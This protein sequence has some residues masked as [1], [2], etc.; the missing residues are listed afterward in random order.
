MRRLLCVAAVVLIW[1]PSAPGHAVSCSPTVFIEALAYPVGASARGIAVADFDGD[2]TPDVATANLNP[3][4]VSVLLNDGTG[5][6]GSPIATP[7]P[8]DPMAIAAADLRGTG[9]MDVVVA[10]YNGVYVLLGHGDGTFDPPTFSPSETDNIASMVIGKFDSNASPDIV[11]GPSYSSD[12]ISV[13]PGIGDGTF[14]TALVTLSAAPSFWMTAADIHDDGHL[15]LVTSGGNSGVVIVYPGLGDGTFGPNS[16]FIA[17][18]SLYGVTTG[19]LDEDG[20]LDLAV[21]SG[22]S[23]SI[24]LG[25]GSGGF[26][27]ALQYAANVTAGD[28]AVGD[29]DQDG[30]LDIVAAEPQDYSSDGDEVSYLRGR[31]DGSFEPGLTYAAGGTLDLALADLNGDSLLDVVSAGG[32]V[33]VS[34]A[35]PDGSLLAVPNS[36]LNG[37]SNPNFTRGDWNGDRYVDFAWL[38]GNQ[39]LV[40]EATGDGRFREIGTLDAGPN[41]QS[42][43]VASGHF[44]DPG[45]ADLVVSTYSDILLFQGNGDG[46]FQAPVSIFNGSGLTAIEVGDLDGDGAD[47]IVAGPNCCGF[48]IVAL[49]GNGEG[50]FDPAV[51]TSIAG[52][53]YDLVSASLTDASPPGASPRDDLIVVT[54][55]N[56]QVLLSNGDGTFAVTTTIPGFNSSVAVGDFNGGGADLLISSGNPSLSLYPGNGD[57][58]FQSPIVIALST[59]GGSVAAGYYNADSFLDFAVRTEGNIFVFFGLGDLHFLAPIRLTTDISATFVETVDFTGNGT[60]DLAAIGQQGIAAFRNSRLGALVRGG[61]SVLIG[62]AVVLEAGAS[63]Y[64]SLTYQWRKDGVPLS[65]GGRISGSQTATLAIDP[66]SFSDA[67][68]Y[69]VVVTDLCATATSNPAILSVEFADVPDSSPFHDDIIAVATAGITGGCGGADF[70]PTSPVRRDQMAVF[71]L[72]AEHGA[73]YTPPACSGVFSDVACPGPFT[74]WVE[75]L[76]TEGV[77]A[78]CG[79]GNYCPDASVTRAQMAVFLLKTSQ[80]SGYGPPPATGIFGDVPAGSFAADFIED[81]YNRGITGGCSSSP[82]LYCPNNAVLRQQMAT[83]LV[84]TFLGP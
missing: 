58:T 49:M 71:L 61:G 65:D 28:L 72:K 44:I 17:G 74:D 52:D 15:D 7:I 80:G 38:S 60:P 26:E 8:N 37:T 9:T 21:G 31:G 3:R 34:L 81:L 46:T 18:A 55:G 27:A 11:L 10:T 6:L 39:V 1:A 29:L 20:N 22:N 64:G 2:L 32:D 25:D 5:G 62:S 69:D 63:G 68:S 73:A 33:F 77:T 41:V 48:S 53:V 19:D 66:V 75:Q 43:G 12:E 23:I 70:C 16:G 56:V 36:R 67:G 59:A 79:G 57:G 24:L 13:L 54:Q 40:I 30:F 50:T 35:A 83:F 14:G 78:G 4:S 82:L 76:A 47:D 51:Q 45:P 42:Y 84:R